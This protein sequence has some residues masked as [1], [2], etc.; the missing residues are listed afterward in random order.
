M[1]MFWFKK[2]DS[3]DVNLDLGD[4]GD[5]IFLKNNISNKEEM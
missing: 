2:K 5:Y 3:R 4:C 1:N